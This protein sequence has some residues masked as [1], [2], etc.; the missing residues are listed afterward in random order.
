MVLARASAKLKIR[1][2]VAKNSKN[3]LFFKRNLNPFFLI[4]YFDFQVSM[5]NYYAKEHPTVFFS[6][7]ISGLSGKFPKIIF[8]YTEWY[9][10]VDFYD[11]FK[12]IFKKTRI[13]FWNSRLYYANI[14]IPYCYIE[15][16]WFQ[17]NSM[18]FKFD[19]NE[20]VPFLLK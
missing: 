10:S 7:L 19:I 9:V 4:I 20:F 2:W 14:L 6:T 16:S 1:P 5:I 11:V 12:S 17:H 18:N 15:I 13:S 3:C 8:R